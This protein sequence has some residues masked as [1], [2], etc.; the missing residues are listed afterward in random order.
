MD[1]VYPSGPNDSWSDDDSCDEDNDEPKDINGVGADGTA[2]AVGSSDVVEAPSSM[3]D[4]STITMDSPPRL[5]STPPV[6]P[7]DLSQPAAP[8]ANRT[9]PLTPQTPPPSAILP[10]SALSPPSP[11]SRRYAGRRMPM[12]QHLPH[13]QQQGRS[14]TLV[15]GHGS[16]RG[17]P[18]LAQTTIVTVPASRSEGGGVGSAFLHPPPPPADLQHRAPPVD[19]HETFQVLTRT[20]DGSNGAGGRFVPHVVTIS[21]DTTPLEN[22]RESSS[23]SQTI[24]RSRHTRPRLSQLLDACPLDGAKASAVTCVKFSPSTDF[25][26]I[27][28][29]VREPLLEY[30]GN[31]YHPVTAL[32]RIRGGMAHVSTMLSS[33]DDV[34]IARFHPESGYGFVYGTKQGRVRVQSPRPWNFYDC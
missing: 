7:S 20:S 4:H 14:R 9:F 25:C 19:S 2:S 11:P 26:L 1:A 8:M 21:L 33:D 31:Q 22:E 30:N 15:G 23:A 32:Y 17:A 27:G 29:G 5:S 10:A 16:E 34:N 24:L 6:Q 28:Y 18:A 12:D 3:L 13:Q